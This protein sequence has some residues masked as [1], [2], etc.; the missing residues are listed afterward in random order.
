MPPS[1]ISSGRCAPS[2]AVALPLQLYK[3]SLLDAIAK[4]AR[5]RETARP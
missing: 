4:L 3:T 5:R 2:E 1:A